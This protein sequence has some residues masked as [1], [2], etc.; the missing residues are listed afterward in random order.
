[1]LYAPR[2]PLS[3]FLLDRLRR[4]PPLHTP[5]PAG[6]VDSAGEDDLHLALHL[7][8]ELHYQGL[9]GV[10][11]AWEWEPTLLAFRR[12]LEDRFERELRGALGPAAPAAASDAPAVAAG[13]RAMAAEIAGPSLSRYLA[14]EATAEQFREF[15]VHRSIYHLKEA[16]PHTWAI[17]RL[18]GRAKAALVEIQADEYGGGR[19]ERM[20]SA[21]FARTMRALGL[22]DRPG[23]YVDLV[24]A[25]TLATVN[26]MSFLGLHR[27][28][29]AALAGHLALFEMTSSVPNRRYGDG[30]RRLGYPPDATGFFDEHVTADAVHELVAINDL[31]G[32][33]AADGLGGDVLFGARALA[34]LDERW[35]AHILGAWTAGRSSLRAP[36]REAVP[37]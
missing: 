37:A 20:H 4:E 24:P 11:D 1:M 21:L 6:D 26:L 33:L 5:P 25:A 29:R 16:D 23:A 7:C 15:V 17:P 12:T 14:R 10:D 9:D 2:G 28:W 36:L 31:A 8:Y 34:L 27:R 35:A 19:P 30:L 22:D 32:P 18:T 13:L 3:A